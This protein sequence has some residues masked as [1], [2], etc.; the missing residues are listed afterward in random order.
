MT[1]TS[2][3]VRPETQPEEAMRGQAGAPA[4]LSVVVIVVTGGT[5]LVVRCCRSGERRGFV[6]LATVGPRRRL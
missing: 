1:T 4:E 5:H 2:T 6:G 3:P